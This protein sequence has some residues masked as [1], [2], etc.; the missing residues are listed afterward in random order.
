MD[1]NISGAVHLTELDFDISA[2]PEQLAQIEK[3]IEEKGKQIQE[4]ISKTWK[5]G[6]IIQTGNNDSLEKQLKEAVAEMQKLRAEKAKLVNAE[7][8]YNKT[9]EQVY[10][11]KEKAYNIENLLYQK[12]FD[13]NSNEVK[14][15]KTLKEQT[16]ELIKQL[17][18]KNQLTDE[19]KEQL[20]LLQKQATEMQNAAQKVTSSNNNTSVKATVVDEQMSVGN[21]FKNFLYY[22]AFGE[23]TQYAAQAAKSIANVETQMVSIARVMGLSDTQVKTLRTDLMN[24]GVE[25]GSSFEDVAEIALR[26]AQAGY[27]M[28]DTLK[29]TKASLL[30]LNTAE[31][32]VENSTNSLIGIMQQWGLQANQLSGL[33]DKLN[34]TAD[35]NA[36]TTQDLVDGLLNVSSVAKTAGISLNDTIGIL[37]AMK[38]A[39]GRSGKEVGNAFKSILAYIQRADS[40]KAFDK[41]GIEVYANKATGELLPMM[42]ILDNMQKK[43]NG[44]SAEMQDAFVTAADSAGLFNE[45]LAIALGMEQEYQEAVQKV[46]DAQSRGMTQ[47][48]AGV[49]RR[50]YYIALMENFNKVLKVSSE[51]LNAEGYSAKEN[52]RT[53]ETLQ[54]KITALITALQ[55]LA[56][57]AADAGFLDIAKGAVDATKALTEFIGKTGGLQNALMAVLG[58][59]LLIKR[60]SIASNVEKVAV[61]IGTAIPI[62]KNYIQGLNGVKTVQ[63]ETATT[64]TAMGAAIN[65]ALGFIGLAMTVLSLVTSAI[66]AYNSAM[67]EA[68]QKTINKAQSE[69]EEIDTLNDLINKYK[70]LVESENQDNNT[71][72]E[73]KSIQEQINNLVGKQAGNVDLVNGK[74]DEQLAKLK[75]ITKEKARQALP[76]AKS[77]KILAESNLKKGVSYGGLLGSPFY[78]FNESNARRTIEK[79][80]SGD[81]RLEILCNGDFLG[82]YLNSLAPE[83]ALKKLDEWQE[84]LNKLSDSGVDVSDGLAYITKASEELQSKLDEVNKTTEYYN[85]LLDIINGKTQENTTET[86]KNTSAKQAATKTALTYEDV[87]NDE[88]ATIESINKVLATQTLTETQYN[89]LIAKRTKLQE[90]RNNT[91]KDYES[92]IS[93][94]NGYIQDL[95]SG[96][97]LTAEQI[98][99]LIELYP[100]LAGHIEETADGYKIETSALQ[101][102]RAE[103]I[104]KSKA[105]KEAQAQDTLNVL[106]ETA[107]RLGIYKTEVAAIQ[108]LA[109]AQNFLAKIEAERAKKASNIHSSDDGWAYKQW[110]DGIKQIEDAT[111]NFIGVQTALDKLTDS[112]YN[113]IGTSAEKSASSAKSAGSK[114]SEAAQKAF[115]DLEYYH[116]MGL[117]S[118]AEYYAELGALAD[119][120]YAKDSSEWRDIQ[121]KIHNYNEEL[122]NTKHTLSELTEEF[123]KFNELGIYTVKEQIEYFENLRKTVA[124]TQDQLEELNSKLIELYKQQD[125]DWFSSAE[126][127]LDNYSDKTKETYD[128]LLDEKK[129]YYEKAIEAAKD[130][131][132][133][134]IESVKSVYEAQ[135]QALKDLKEAKEKS[136]DAEDYN[137]KRNK[138]LEER[139]YWEQRTGKDAVEKIKDIDEQIAEL[140]K[141][142]QRELEDDAIDSQIELLEKQMDNQ[143]AYLEKMRDAKIAALEDERDAAIQAAEDERDAAVNAAKEKWE[144]IESLFIDANKNLIALAAIYAPELYNQFKN[145]FTDPMANDIQTLQGLFAQLMIFKSQISAKGLMGG[146]LSAGASIEDNAVPITGGFF[147]EMAQAASGGETTKDG[148]MMTHKDEFIANSEITKGLRSLTSPDFLSKLDVIINPEI[149]KGLRQ[150]SAANTTSISNYN[151]SLY[152]R[153]EGQTVNKYI[154]LKIEN[155]IN[156]MADADLLVNKIIRDLSK[157]I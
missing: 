55:N 140:D 157:K 122:K 105:I 10:R 99:N 5:I 35:R 111:K 72:E 52:A 106:K 29:M 133:E 71:R 20:S 134:E 143:I 124:L 15:A 152:N 59:I 154:E 77:A 11:L 81:E 70:E 65:N 79:V 60:Q 31:L 97:S 6:D 40:L 116:D 141:D 130:A 62:L 98:M 95:N 84:K 12:G 129:E 66:S 110:E 142:R 118:D 51:A 26:F 132:E 109:D 126:E 123:D 88:S 139:F 155:N 102:L 83:E 18:L 137:S 36:I 87:I 64:A 156:D 108:N 23:I 39:S 86:E 9:S 117:K 34:Y 103:I 125:E 63:A 100:E 78:D 13:K 76:D 112:L 153:Y 7:E 57:Q 47:A 138:L 43:W 24:L 3:L 115:D 93:S 68:R 74:L 37:T 21:K 45:E 44:L 113:K 101:T 30:A 121:V 56:V 19:E 17:K 104:Q 8:K 28:Q 107:N 27:N 91:L 61:S 135:I 22:R 49:Y 25:Y 120:Y 42:T 54:K 14:A 119:K 90:E 94:L 58:V 150:I 73:I 48:A 33:I 50:N 32:D 146:S 128:N 1:E 92:Q 147:S 136:R 114:I 41:M 80:L 38:E 89:E 96:E 85:K 53:M 69:K 4:I 149:I 127:I 46:N 82:T 131:A 148:I 145:W 144:Q 2:I 75:E 67:E 16:D 151:S